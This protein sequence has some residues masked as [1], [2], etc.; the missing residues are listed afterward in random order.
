M[1]QISSVMLTDF[2]QKFKIILNVSICI[3]FSHLK[4]FGMTCQHF[5]TP[6]IRKIENLS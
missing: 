1:V 4:K 2:G 5:S 3:H 6:L